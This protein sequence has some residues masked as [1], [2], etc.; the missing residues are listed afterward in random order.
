M[1]RSYWIAS[2][3]AALLLSVLPAQAQLPKDP[4]ERKKVI[5]QI[6]TANARQLTLFDREGKEVGTVGTRDL[7]NMV[8]LSPD[9]TRIAAI[10]PDLEKETN[11]LWILDVATGKGPQITFSKAREQATTPVWSPDGREIAYVALRDGSFGI[12]RK[13][14]NGEGTEE[15]LYKA[16]APVSLTDWSIDGRFLS[17]FSTDLAGG[18][19]YALPLNSGDRKPVEMLRSQY[20][21][22]AARFSADSRF[23]S[24]ISNQSGKS[25]IYVRPVN[26]AGTGAAPTGGPWQI[27]DGG[28]GMAFWRRDGKE[29]YYLAADRSIMAV[30]ITTAPDFEFGKPKVL[31]RIPDAIGIGPGTAMISRDGERVIIAVPPPQLRQLTVFDRSGKVVSTVGSAGVYAQPGFSPDGKRVVVMRNDLQNTNQDIWTYDLA[32]GKGYAVT[33]DT[34]PDNAPIW[35]PDGS[36][37]AYVSTRQSYSGIYRK[38]WDGTG[39]EE[40]LFRYTPGAGMVLTDWSPDGKFMTFF[41]GVLL[42]VPVTNNQQPLDR[43][44]IDWL[45]ED[46][47]AVQGRFSP[48]GRYM[49]YLSNEKNVERLEVYVRPFDAN[50]PDAPPAGAP[51]QISKNGAIGMVNWRQDGKEMY[52]MTRDWEVMAVDITTTPTFQAGTPRLLFKMNGPLPGNPTQWKNVSSDGE[53]FIFAMPAR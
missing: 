20:Q 7:Y 44:A 49:A 13:P 28:T 45:R 31:F 9:R 1:K 32:T 30:S 11:D 33:N 21:I 39:A 3:T 40:L 15:L 42:L 2:I 16:S 43:K 22:Q 48:E 8:I 38:S 18:A 46:Y 26:P 47:D 36:K 14:S 19:L 23:I 50:K 17:F 41:T 4:E 24:Y 34:P 51:V 52:F 27:S 10:K 12:F 25:E 37:V 6:M 53:R 5:A 29:L 35:S